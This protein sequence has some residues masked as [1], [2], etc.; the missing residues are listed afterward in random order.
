MIDDKF[1][2]ELSKQYTLQ[3]IAEKGQFAEYSQHEQWRNTSFTAD[4]IDQA[5]DEGFRKAIE[6]LKTN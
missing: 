4:D 6:L 1:I 2:C 3:R 5:Y